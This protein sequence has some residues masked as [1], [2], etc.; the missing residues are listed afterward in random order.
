MNLDHAA[1]YH[2][3]RLAGERRRKAERLRFAALHAL[4]LL[5]G[6]LAGLQLGMRL[7]RATALPPVN[8]D[9]PPQVG[10][11]HAPARAT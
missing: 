8:V 10:A 6:L 5:I 9:P 1:T 3:R 7:E 11:L 2:A 4:M